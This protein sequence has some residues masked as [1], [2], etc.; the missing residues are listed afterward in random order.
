MPRTTNNSSSPL[1]SSAQDTKSKSSS[2][3]TEYEELLQS[4]LFKIDEKFEQFRN[5][6][7]TELR[8]RDEKI[9]ELEQH[10][11]TLKRD[12]LS[13]WNHIDDLENSSRRDEFVMSGDTIS[14]PTRSSI[15]PISTACDA[16]KT[17]L[18]ISLPPGDILST[19]RLGPMPNSQG[20][21]KRSLLVRVREH[22]VKVDI[23]RA[24]KSVRPNNLY[25]NDNLTT[26]RSRI[27]YALRQ[28]KRRKTDILTGC[29]SMDGRVFAWIKSAT[30]QGRGS[31]IFLNTW[32]ELE[33][34]CEQTLKLKTCDLVDGTAR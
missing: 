15:N 34:F 30:P 6:V 31:R 19:R 33:L 32:N 12:V 16:L 8:G 23:I 27:L 4:V 10:V 29:G 14:V 25:I 18:N 24:C 2:R 26:N 11:S 22:Q 9:A 17:A 1:L 21:D 20:T 3:K 28:A 7:L 5:E 13:L